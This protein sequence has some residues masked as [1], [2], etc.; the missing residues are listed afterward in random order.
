M[1]PPGAAH[2][3]NRGA[4][5]CPGSDGRDS[6]SQEPG[7][8]QAEM[9]DVPAGPRQA[10][11]TGLP[12]LLTPTHVPLKGKAFPSLVQGRNPNKNTGNRMP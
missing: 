11:E 5:D 10:E 2:Y 1:K 7:R 6:S 8:E 3:V 4:G 9:A 12:G